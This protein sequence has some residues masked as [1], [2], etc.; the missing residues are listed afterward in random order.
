MLPSA[1]PSFYIPVRSSMMMK[2]TRIRRRDKGTAW[3]RYVWTWHGG[4]A[5]AG[6]D[7]AAARGQKKLLLLRRE[8]ISET[9]GVSRIRVV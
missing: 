4:A 9:L 3:R 8:S 6:S 5:R 2:W 7:S 1:A